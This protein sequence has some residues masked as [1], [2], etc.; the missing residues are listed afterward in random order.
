MVIG[1]EADGD[2][3][4][5]YPNPTIKELQGNPVDADSPNTGDALIWNGT[6]GSGTCTITAG[7][8]AVDDFAV[9]YNHQTSKK[10]L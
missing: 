1:Q 8:R 3:T 2:L 5:N 9:S 4:G 10:F 7:N 6:A